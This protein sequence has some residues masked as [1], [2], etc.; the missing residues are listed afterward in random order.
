M[1]LSI[2]NSMKYLSS[3]VR[4][5]KLTALLMVL[6]GAPAQAQAPAWQM[7]VAAAGGGSRVEATV[8]DASGN[9]YVAGGFYGTVDFGNTTLVSVGSSDIFVAKW[10]SASNR[11]V[12]AQRAGGP[13]YDYAAALALNGPNV[14][15]TGAFIGTAGFGTTSLTSTAS[16][17]L[18]VAKLADAGSSAGFSWAQRAGGNSGDFSYAVV[19]NGPNVYVAGFSNSS[20]VALGGIA[21][22]N[23]NFANGFVAKLLDAGNTS[24]F[25][26]A[27]SFGNGFTRSPL[28]VAGANVY[29]GG[30]Y[31]GT[32]TFGGFSLTSPGANV[33]SGFVAK[34]TDAGSS[35]NFTW[36]QQ[37]SGTGS[38]GLTALAVS[39]SGALYG[40]GYFS[41]TAAFGGSSVTSAGSTDAF[42]AKLADGGRTSS[43]AWGQRA[44]GTGDDQVDALAVSGAVVYV[45]GSFSGAATFGATALNSVGNTDLFVARLTDAGNAG[46]FAWAQQAGG[47][48]SD[49]ATTAAVAPNGIIHVGGTVNPPAFFGSQV[50]TGPGNSEVGFL[51]ALTDATGLAATSSTALAGLNVS[52]NPAHDV[53][54]VQLPP[55]F[56]ARAATFTLL[57]ALGRVV[58]IQT[59]TTNL[60]AEL[61]LRGLAPGLYALRVAAGSSTATR[62]LVVE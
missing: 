60:K 24:T 55:T 45:A 2:Y 11:F 54:T 26:W 59:A 19:V 13:D 14:Y 27:H 58:R 51:A 1:V 37:A 21:L 31:N 18:F 9:V 57:D 4:L 38:T 16:F 53:A 8:A 17:D 50:V 43:F 56:G 5:L 39:A 35:S 49:R 34:L 30:A 23:P 40:A 6:N 61:D 62:R 32:A 42:V 15:V 48:G 47:V 28:A 7:A 25:A 41:G 12:W 22:T 20:S 36:V 29:V 52:P 10:S 3:I 46:N 44:G 33:A